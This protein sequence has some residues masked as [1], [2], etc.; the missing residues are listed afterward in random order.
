MQQLGGRLEIDTAS[1]VYQDGG[2]NGAFYAEAWALVH[3]LLA[4]EGSDRAAVAEYAG[5]LRS[6]ED[7]TAAFT[8][9]LGDSAALERAIDAH[10]R[11]APREPARAELLQPFYQCAHQIFRRRRAGGDADPAPPDEP[12]GVELIGAIDQVGRQTKPLCN[13]A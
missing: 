4:G 6:G 8:A 11:R 7:T 10:L 5:L 13:F 9:V 1:H 2:A 3:W 12:R